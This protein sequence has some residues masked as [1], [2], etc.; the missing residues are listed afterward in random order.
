M[1]WWRIDPETGMP[2]KDAASR[3]SRPPEV[4]FP[5]ALP[6][7][8]GDSQAHYLGDS[9]RG[10]AADTA[11]Q[12]QALL[13]PAESLSAGE[14]RRLFL[15]RVPPERLRGSGPKAAKLLQIVEAMWADVD[16]VYQEE[17]GR[18]TRAAER[19]WVG[20]YAVRSL[21]ARKE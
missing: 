6:G 11:R 8:D 1:G 3:L 20:E 16:D 14:G 4:V 18:P 5:N 7:V 13:G 21:T 19:R 12:G 9:A 10:F 17:W 15:D 2:A